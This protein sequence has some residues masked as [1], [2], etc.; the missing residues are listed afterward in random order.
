MLILGVVFYNSVLQV[1]KLRHKEIGQ[2]YTSSKWE[3]LDV[4]L[5]GSD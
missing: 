3:S 4:T 5:Y 2:I 1:N